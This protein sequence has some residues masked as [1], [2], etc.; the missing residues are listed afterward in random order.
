MIPTEARSPWAITAAASSKPSVTSTPLH[1]A[2]RGGAEQSPGCARWGRLGRPA[3]GEPGATTRTRHLVGLLRAAS[4]PLRP[5]P[6]GAR[7]IGVED[8][9]Q[10]GQPVD[11]HLGSPAPGLDERRAVASVLGKA[12]HDG[13]PQSHRDA[14]GDHRSVEYAGSAPGEVI[15]VDHLVDV[16]LLQGAGQ[17]VAEDRG[18]DGYGKARPLVAH[19]LTKPRRAPHR[20]RQD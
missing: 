7:A 2:L 17:G 9:E 13:G 15:E 20:H 10:R 18:L 3:A 8:V 12:D 16:E 1:L 6:A 14:D 4:G 19:S 5:A 11:R